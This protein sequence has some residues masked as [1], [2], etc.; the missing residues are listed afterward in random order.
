[1]KGISNKHFQKSFGLF[2][3]ILCLIESVT[4]LGQQ[5]IS[6]DTIIRKK[7]NVNEGF[8]LKFLE[9]PG[10]GY[11]WI[12][13]TPYDSTILSIRQISTEL[14]AGNHPVGGHY[15]TTYYYQSLK[16]ENITLVY[17]YQRPW[18]KDKLFKCKVLIRRK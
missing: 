2:F 14:M 1:M 3:F 5:P 4:S 9:C 10:A 16:K 13:S 7:I 12:L 8:E 18:L 6:S 17:Y 15:V 11:G